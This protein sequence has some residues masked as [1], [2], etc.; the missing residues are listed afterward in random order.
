VHPA[1]SVIFFT[2]A[3]GAGYGLLAL[4]GIFSAVDLIPA[5]QALGAAGFTLG[6]GAVT[7]GLLSSTFHLGHPE[8]SWRAFSQ[9]RTSWL[10][11][12]G[13]LAVLTYGPVLLFAYSWLF[14]ESDTAT[15]KVLGGFT[16]LS[17]LITVYCTAMIYA[18]LKTIRA[19]SNGWTVAAYLVFAIMTGGLGLNALVHTWGAGQNF[20]VTGVVLIFLVVGFMIKVAYWRHID[21]PVEGPNAGTATGLGGVGQVRLLDPPHTEENYL[22]REMGYRIARKH[23]AKLRRLVLAF[24]FVFPFLLTGL[25]LAMPG[26]PALFLVTLAGFVGGFG[27][28]MERW[29]FFAEARHAVTLYYGQ[30]R[31]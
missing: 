15:F 5:E 7:L 21:M 22:L 26:W 9:W 14:H 30:D 8:R 23:S 12:E 19:W 25:S 18:S 20:V 4:L 13:V 24:A 3:S 29:L 16:A 27:I 11:R 10:S 17:A 6:L 2:A 1:F 31:I 28:F